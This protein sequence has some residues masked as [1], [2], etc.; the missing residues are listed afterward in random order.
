MISSI[1]LPL[2]LLGFS[3]QTPTQFF[4]LQRTA[5]QDPGRSGEELVLDAALIAQLNAASL[6]AVRLVNVPF[7]GGADV[8]LELE[9][10]R[11]DFSRAELV[12]D[13]VSQGF[14]VDTSQVS[15]WSG[16]VAGDPTSEAFFG[17]SA[18]GS[19]GGYRTAGEWVHLLAEPGPD[20][21]WQRPGARLIS[22]RELDALGA[23][24]D[25]SC[26]GALLTTAGAQAP[27]P[28]T[29]P[30]SGQVSGSIET[31]ECRVAWETDYQLFTRF[32]TYNG[33][34]NYTIMLLS[35][36]AYRYRE[37]VDV[38]L[39][40]VHLGFHTDV[41]D[42]WATPDV[43]GSSAGDLLNEFRLAWM[44]NIPNNGHLAHFVS[45][46][47]LGGGVAYLETLCN[48][49]FG[50]AVS[51]N[52]THFGRLPDS[53]A[54]QGPLTWDFYVIS[55]EAGH[56]FGSPHTFDYNPPIDDCPNT[57]TD[58]GTI[59]SYCHLCPGGNAN[60]TT[61]FHPRAVTRMRNRAEAS[62]LPLYCG[63]VN[64]CRG[65]PNSFSAG[66]GVMAY[67]GSTRMASNNLT[68]EALDV[69]PGT[70]G[71][72][73]YGDT[74]IQVPFGEGLRCVG[75]G[76]NAIFRLLPVT[77]A[78]GFGAN[79]R[80]LD[81]G[82]PPANAGAGAITPGSTWNFQYWFRDPMGGPEGFNLTDGLAVKFCP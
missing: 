16:Q 59:M 36:V 35:A 48:S 57:C 37:Q 2:A 32:N 51:A 70:F 28:P 71:L 69:V 56:N 14:G 20:G 46:A 15:I 76:S 13:G 58:M 54:T 12:L 43:P 61:Y 8:V 74:Q 64:Y 27:A 25:A 19:R 22:G 42:G 41:N 78:D 53:P 30:G 38:E 73:Y 23:T 49:S 6:D 40:P 75:A 7:P 33:M 44:G 72:F 66:G 45:G 17:F 67:S 77:A 63:A 34:R 81:L 1:L 3:S 21:T 68:L 62:C 18:S 10:V 29:T 80:A 65:R 9:R 31:L 47:G 11:V 5:T 26:E 79:S 4:P 82:A 60:I 52:I 55:H 50:F 24:F 39:V